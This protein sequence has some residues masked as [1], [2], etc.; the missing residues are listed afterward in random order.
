ME[1]EARPCR[2][3]AT[4]M[5]AELYSLDMFDVLVAVVGRCHQPEGRSMSHRER[6]AVQTIGEQHL[7][8]CNRSTNGKAAW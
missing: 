2:A 5:Y 3:I 8:C 7:R 6:R 4:P 1:Y